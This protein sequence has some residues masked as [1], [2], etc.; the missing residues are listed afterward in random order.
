MKRNKI[1]TLLLA[2]FMS[3]T[4]LGG[5][6]SSNADNNSSTTAATQDSNSTTEAQQ[7]TSAQ[8]NTGD[9]IKF[10]MI[11]PLT[12]DTSVYGNAVKNGIELAISE[13]NAAGGVLD[14]QIEFVPLDDK[15][16]IA[17]SVTAYNN[18][19]SQEITALLG[20]VTS[21]PSI[22]I[23]E[24]AAADRLPM[25]TPTGT[26]QAITEYGDN[27]FRVCFTD[28][29]QGKIMAT[30]AA[31]N[32]GAKT[33]AIIYNTSDDYSQGLATAFQ[34]TAESKGLTIV[35]NEGY[36]SDDTD[37]RAQ[38]TKI[39]SANPDVLFV[40]DYYKKVALIA[41]QARD[42]GFDKPLLGGDGWDGVLEVLDES[43]MKVLDNCYFSNHYSVTDTEEV[44]ANFVSNF[45]SKYN[46]T[47]N[48]FAA[49]GYDS[50]YIMADAVKKAG[51]AD[52]EAIN[53]A[54]KDTSYNGVTGQIKFDEKG[55]PIKSVSIIKLEGGEAKLDSKITAE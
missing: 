15:N 2:G 45:K 43:N 19:T 4:A 25:L 40:P 39:Q 31:D 10:G 55:D 6:T 13:I 20:A 50:A 46:E 30:F 9:T 3:I 35:A 17:E 54:L 26:A 44:V 52:K 32:L 33:A 27:I 36:G 48:S 47:P 24:T 51:S 14:K 21:K 11:G 37:F 34:E 1:L 8:T 28:P 38:L 49:L 5:C 7:D 18:I 16:D 12:G 41:A 29:F 53:T 42:A 22:A 23:A